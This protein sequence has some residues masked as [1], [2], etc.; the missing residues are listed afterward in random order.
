MGCDHMRR[1]RKAQENNG[2]YT[3]GPRDWPA[4]GHMGKHQGGQ[5][6]ED[7]E[8]GKHVG[9]GLYWGFKGTARQGRVNNLALVCV[10]NFRE[11]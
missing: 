4:L 2:Y 10:S 11:L 5:K 8:Q 3:I 9:H 6:A 1:H 7:G